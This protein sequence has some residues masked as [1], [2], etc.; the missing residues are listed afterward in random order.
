MRAV[1][2][3]WTAPHR[4]RRGWHWVSEKHH[5]FSWVLSV[6][7]A[8]RHYL[9]TALYTDTEGARLLVDGLGLPFDHV[10]VKLNALAHHDPDWWMLGKLMTYQSQ[11]DPFLHIDADVYLWNRL[12]DRLVSAPVFAQNPEDVGG[13]NCYDVDLCESIIRQGDGEVPLEWQWYRENSTAPQA[14]CCGIL[15]ANETAFI[16]YYAGIAIRLL[17]NPRNCAAF[18]ALPDKRIYNPL[19]E[20]FVLSACAN[21]H[22]VPIE[23]LFES[24]DDACHRA[25]KT[26]YTHLI[27]SAKSNSDVAK[28]LEQRIA[29][30]YPES[31]E[32]CLSLAAGCAET[33]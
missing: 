28:R 2:S 32:R 6:E 24:W 20:Q 22:G 5:L 11:V 15:G 18:T 23:Y 30:E 25:F 12:P 27:A 19:F 33:R 4:I 9:D 1:W 10:S 16:R 14:A 3:F 7:L 21:Y 8:K 13:A 26:G 17:E 29:T 31:Y